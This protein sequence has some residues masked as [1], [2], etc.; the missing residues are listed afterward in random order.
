MDLTPKALR[1][2]KQRKKRVRTFG[3]VKHWR[4]PF[5]IAIFGI[6]I[7]SFVSYSI[8]DYF[9]NGKVYREQVHRAEVLQG[10]IEA[11]D[12]RAMSAYSRVLHLAERS[13]FIKP[14]PEEVAVQKQLDELNR[15]M[16]ARFS[17]LNACF[18]VLPFKY[19]SKYAAQQIFSTPMR[20]H[21]ESVLSRQEYE[22][23]RLCYNESYLKERLADMKSRIEGT[24]HLEILA[25]S[26]VY[27]AI[28]WS[29][30]S[31]GPRLVVSE[32]IGRS[33]QFPFVIEKIAKGS[34][35]MFI[36]RD[37]GGM[38]P[39]PF[40][41]K[42]GENKQ[43][44]IQLPERIPAGMAFVPGGEFICGGEHSPIYRKHTRTLPS[45][46]IARKEVS[47]ADYIEFWKSLSDPQLQTRMISRVRLSADEPEKTAWDA[48]GRLND[49]RL[50][51]EFPVV[52]ISLDAAKAF[53]EWKSRQ[54]G[55][56][57]RLPSAFEWEKAARG[58]D[59]RTYPWGYD[60]EA[61]ADLALIRDNLS[62]KDRYP[63]FAPPGRFLRDIS[64]Y[65]VYDMGGN[66]REM[67]TTLFPE[68]DG[69]YQIKGGSAFTPATFLPCS[70]SSKDRMIPTDVGF[71]YIQEIP[72][73]P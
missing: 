46:F 18:G 62:G 55:Q 52:G 58:V 63:F 69:L 5:Q 1:K 42:H 26:E 67:T 13:E 41:I 47:F 10:E 70:F 9:K 66:V 68:S 71:R 53:C 72:K 23:A 49:D 11:M 17:E 4:N 39:Y 16:D 14:T 8:M 37:D 61:Q 22:R 43:L 35:L 3:V 20:Q 38:T 25:G 30:K 31:D 65:N 44:E 48:Q 6:A 7:V 32:H 54:T 21:I 15:K 57:I 40:Y 27:E 28:I 45:F 12:G 36:T 50:K 2:K 24:G 51:L 33:G 59:G 29:V 64:V 34:Y 60:F 73:Q 19:R 56:R